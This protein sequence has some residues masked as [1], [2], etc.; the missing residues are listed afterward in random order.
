MV[1]VLPGRLPNA[2]PRS[3]AGT[4]TGLPWEPAN[5][6]GGLGDTASGSDPNVYAISSFGAA[7]YYAGSSGTG[8]AGA[9]GAFSL[10][11]LLRRTS[12]SVTNYEVIYDARNPT[13]SGGYVLFKSSSGDPSPQVYSSAAAAIV[14][15]STYGVSG[16]GVLNKWDRVAFVHD[17]TNGVHYV[18]GVAAGSSVMTF[19]A[20]ASDRRPS[21]GIGYLN[22]FPSSTFDVAAVAVSSTSL[23]AGQ[24]A[25]LDTAIMARADITPDI[26]PG[27]QNLWSAKANNRNAGASW[28]DV[29]GGVALAR[30]GTPTAISVA[31]IWGT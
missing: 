1:Y 31:P 2:F 23:S 8:Y 27:V 18:N 19:N 20:G 24:I 21:I 13:A 4:R 22:T 10:I 12:N 26:V 16:A 6:V 14:K 5:G 3:A 30:T 25:A 15:Y 7:A 17:G 11:A 28:I 9:S 29:V